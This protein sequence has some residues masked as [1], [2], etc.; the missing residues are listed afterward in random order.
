MRRRHPGRYF[1]DTTS[2]VIAVAM[3]AASLALFAATAIYGVSFVSRLGGAGWFIYVVLIG[4]FALVF[5]PIV[6]SAHGFWERGSQR[7]R[8]EVAQ[9]RTEQSAK[10]RLQEHTDRNQAEDGDPDSGRGR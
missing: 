2:R 8:D 4:T 7:H 6:A 3:W 1:S 5:G 9:R 10:Y